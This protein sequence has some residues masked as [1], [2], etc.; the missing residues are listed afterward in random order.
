MRV[1]AGL[2]GGI[3]AHMQLGGKGSCRQFFVKG[4]GAATKADL[5]NGAAPTL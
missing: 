5:P 4:Q 1:F 3:E 2:S